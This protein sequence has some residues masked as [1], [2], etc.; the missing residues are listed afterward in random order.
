MASKKT[1]AA[2]PELV[3]LKIALKWTD[4]EIWRRV[5]VPSNATLEDLH[6]VVQ[7][8]MGWGFSHLHLFIV[9]NRREA[10]EFGPHNEFSRGDWEDEALV[11]IAEIAPRA[12]SSFHYEYDFGDSWIHK[13]TREKTLPPDPS[14]KHPVCLDGA[15]ACP[16]EDCGGLPGYLMNLEILA[17]PSHEEHEEISEWMGGEWDAEKFDLKEVNR[18]LRAVSF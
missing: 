11:T 3:Q 17:D 1:K 4:P 12:R 6:E 7:L 18:R 8:A 9:G 5:V 13:I 14:F 2:A 15:R 10:V 16:P